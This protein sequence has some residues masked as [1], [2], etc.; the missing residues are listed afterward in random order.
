LITGESKKMSIEKAFGHDKV[1]VGASVA[2]HEKAKWHAHW[3]IKKYEGE[4]PVLPFSSDMFLAM[5]PEDLERAGI[6]PIETVEI[7]GN[8]LLND[9]INN[10]IW[11]AV[12]G[13][14]YTPINT[15]DGCIGVGDSSAAASAGQTGLQATTNRQW[16]I[17]AST[18]GTGSS[19]QLVLQATFTTSQANFTWN[20]ICAGST[21]TPSSLPSTGT[22]PPATAHVLNRLVNTN[23]GTKG[24][25]ATWTATLTVTLQ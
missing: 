13:G 7:D 19:Q 6:K 21:T 8:C 1:G 3:T 4:Y 5:T 9:G 23:M 20:E 17:I 24:S 14:S 16:V 15:T 12:I 25:A 22:A 11:P 2:V 18:S 10:I